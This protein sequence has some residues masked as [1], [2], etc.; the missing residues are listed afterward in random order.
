MRL[1]T[2]VLVVA[3]L[4]A[5]ANVYTAPGAQA[6][7]RRHRLVAVAPPNVSIAPQRKVC[8]AAIA[9]QEI[10]EIENFQQ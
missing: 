7:A 4:A 3:A 6:A 9:D 8:A 1:L 5:C 2:T 10:L